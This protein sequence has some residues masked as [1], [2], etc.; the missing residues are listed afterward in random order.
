MGLMCAGTGLRD[1]NVERWV[2]AMV[3]VMAEGTVVGQMM[4]FLAPIVPRCET[5]AVMM[6][7]SAAC[8]KSK[9]FARFQ[10]VSP[11]LWGPGCGWFAES[12]AGRGDDCGAHNRKSGGRE[13]GPGGDTGRR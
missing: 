8:G 13:R 9:Y 3:R 2:L 5:D 7:A 12:L 4:E 1:M 6:V 10:T 11:Y